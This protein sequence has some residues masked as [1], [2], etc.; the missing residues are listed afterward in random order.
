MVFFYVV[1]VHQTEAGW[2]EA[3]EKVAFGAGAVVGTVAF[4][5]SAPI[6]VPTAVVATIG[7]VGVGA[8]ATLIGLGIG[9]G[10]ETAFGDSS[11]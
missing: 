2:A 11:S 4:V 8:G 7:I 10:L 3:L 6:S 9:E 1:P 5:A